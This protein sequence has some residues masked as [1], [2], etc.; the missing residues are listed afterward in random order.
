MT[1]KEQFTHELARALRQRADKTLKESNFI[2]QDE[3]DQ[4]LALLRWETLKAMA[5]D[6]EAGKEEEGSK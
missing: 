2:V 3:Y 1:L 4:R 6:L 5:A